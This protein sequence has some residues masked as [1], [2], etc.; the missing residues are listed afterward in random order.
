M[1]I[2][3]FILSIVISANINAK[4]KGGID[5]EAVMKQMRFEYTQAMKTDSAEKF[6]AH[7]IA[8]N[9][10]LE[11]AKQYPHSKERL[12]KATEGLNKVAIIINAVT[13]PVTKNSLDQV[14][15][16]LYVIDDLRNEYHDKKPSLW[17]RFY[18]IFFGVSEGSEPLIL[19]AD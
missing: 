8:F 1:Y 13:L 18:E 15:K 2:C 7:I 12:Q 14:K 10:Q 9:K 16:D 17:Q 3:L 4:T 6:T 19:I 5:L 11:L